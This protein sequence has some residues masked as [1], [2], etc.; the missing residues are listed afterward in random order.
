M[1]RRLIAGK[2]AI[3]SCPCCGKRIARFERDLYELDAL[4]AQD[5]Y[6]FDG[7]I[8]PGDRTTCRKCGADWFLGGQLHL[9]REGWTWKRRAASWLAAFISWL[10][11]D[12]KKGMSR[13][14]PRHDGE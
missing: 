13:L 14:D 11:W 4:N 2:G 3:V 7:T 9:E 1:S 6:G 10:N 5:F 12:Y 8:Y